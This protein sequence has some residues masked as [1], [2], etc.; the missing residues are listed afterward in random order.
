M[1]KNRTMQAK[2]IKVKKE[3]SKAKK[4]RF[5]LSASA[6]DYNGNSSADFFYSVD[7]RSYS[8]MWWE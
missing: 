2:N 1:A 4:N 5:Y 3:D 8:K 7:P 6:G